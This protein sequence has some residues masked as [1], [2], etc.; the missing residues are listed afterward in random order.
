MTQKSWL[1]TLC[2]TIGLLAFPG[3]VWAN[4][5][6]KPELLLAVKEW[7]TILKANPPIDARENDLQQEFLFRLQF[8]VER[9]YDGTDSSLIRILDFYL[10]LENHP[11]NISHSSLGPFLQ[12]LTRSVKEIR[13]PQ[14]PLW[15]FIQQFMVDNSL[16]SPTSFE[17]S[18]RH[19]DYLNK[20]ETLKAAEATLP[21]ELVVSAP[22]PTSDTSK[23]PELV[24]S[25][26]AE[27]APET[28]ASQPAEGKPDVRAV[29]VID[30]QKTTA[31]TS[32]QPASP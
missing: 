13:E 11:T 27:L 21:T 14:E 22:S 12:I 25:P 8:F 31:D 30:G 29:E 15:P 16:A 2:F 6:S 19:R 18:V 1:L 5:L 3:T 17:E 4:A 10:E 24:Q 7:R 20:Y 28:R 32:A 23:V 9:R 26:G